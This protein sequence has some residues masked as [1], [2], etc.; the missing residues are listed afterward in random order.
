VSTQAVYKHSSS[1]LQVVFRCSEFLRLHFRNP[2]SS[3][4]CKIPTSHLIEESK[5][6]T[7]IIYSKRRYFTEFFFLIA[8]Y[9]VPLYFSLDAAFFWTSSFSSKKRGK[10][11][12]LRVLSCFR[13]CLQSPFNVSQDLCDY[14]DVLDGYSILRYFHILI[15]TLYNLSSKSCLS[16]HLF[17]ESNGI[18]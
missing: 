13:N 9:C 5:A 10:W 12:L 8:Y 6:W 1:L 18:Q 2:R 15:M 4:L 11:V 17:Y 14:S 16:D 3:T 7:L